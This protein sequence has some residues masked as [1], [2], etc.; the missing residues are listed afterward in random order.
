MPGHHRQDVHL[1]ARSIL[2][3]KGRTFAL[4]ARLLP[5]DTAADATLLYAFCRHVD[6]L[7]DSPTAGPSARSELV[8]L[9]EQ[10]FSGS[11]KLPLVREF[12]QMA[13]RRGLSSVSAMKLIDGAISD[14]EDTVLIQNVEQLIEYCYLVAGTVGEMMCPILG[15]TPE[16]LPQAADLGIAM[17]MTNIARDIREDALMG[18]QYI[19][20]NWIPTLSV[21]QLSSHSEQT[22][23]ELTRAVQRL[24][25]MAES[26]YTKARSGLACLPMKNRLGISV[27]ADVYREIG[28][29][30]E[31]RGYEVRRQ[32]TV[33]PPHRKLVRTMR[34]LARCLWTPLGRKVNGECSISGVVHE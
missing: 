13:N 17:Q 1:D 25:R 19:P 12:L 26:R 31:Q 34:T 9:R 27:A 32:R 8:N 5:A 33:V 30:I 22:Q 10:I 14:L 20:A 6:D 4:A 29:C 3:A 18:R 2:R 16:L 11:G 24:L 28:R 7:A 23:S 21:D 15:G